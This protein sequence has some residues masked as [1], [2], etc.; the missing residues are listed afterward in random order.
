MDFVMTGLPHVQCYIDDILIHSE[1]LE[2]HAVH[3]RE[4]LER[5][6]KYGLKL[7]INKCDFG[8]RRI[9]YLGHIISAEGVQPSD[10]KIKAVR[11]FPEPTSVKKIREFTGLCN[12]FRN[13]IKNYALLSGHL[14]RLTK[15][16]CEWTGGPLPL[17]AKTAFEELRNRLCNA[18]LLVFPRKGVPYSISVDAA[19]GTATEPGGLGAILSQ[20]G[21]DGKDHVVA[22][23]SR[24]LKDFER[25]YTPYLLELAAAVWAIDHF[26]V[27]VYG[28][29]FT[30]WT[31]HRPIEK[32]TLLHDK[33]LNRL[34]QQMLI[35]NFVTMYRPGPE[36]G[37][38]DALSRN[39]VDSL[40]VST[41]DFQRL[42]E[43]DAFCF[44]IIRFIQNGVL[45]SNK[46]QAITITYHA[47]NMFLEN[48]VLYYIMRRK[49]MESRQLVVIPR[50]LQAELIHGAH[51]TRYS[52]HSG[53]L[54]T[55]LRL[56]TRYYWPGMTAQVQH[57]IDNCMLCIKC[58]SKLGKAPLHPLPLPELPNQ[59]VHIDLC[60]PYKTTSSGNKYCMV[61]TDAFTKY[62][63][64]VAIPNKEAVTIATALLQ[65][66]VCKFSVMRTL[67]SDR[68]K[69]FDN[70]VL[71]ELCVLM[72]TEKRMSS[73]MNPQSNTAVESWNRSLVK[74]LTMAMSGGSTL[75]WEK[76]LP[77]LEISYNTQVH[78]ST[79]YSPFYLTFLHHPNLPYFDMDDPAVP[80][81]DGS[82][83]TVAFQR[84][85][86]A[87]RLARLNNTEAVEKGKIAYDKKAKDR[88]FEVGDEVLVF[89]PKCMAKD[90]KKF[91]E[92]WKEGYVIIDQTGPISFIVQ[93]GPHG[94]PHAVQ[95][96]RL[97]LVPDKLK[98]PQQIPQKKVPRLNLQRKQ[99]F[100]LFET[101]EDDDDD[102]D[103]DVPLLPIPP[104]PANQ[105]VPTAQPAAAALPVI[106]PPP[107]GG[108][109]RQPDVGQQPPN[110][111]EAIDRLAQ[112]LIG[113]V[114]HTRARG[115]AD[116]Q[117][118]VM[119]TG[120]RKKK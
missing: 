25:N 2:D 13:H 60:G 61:M 41:Y 83:A 99:K 113:P 84:M 63:V 114:R 20:H 33:T 56:Q 68:G 27:Y 107:A 54:K 66:W 73:V 86:K 103:D 79:L 11:D 87:Y 106:P 47:S 77:A 44:D 81:E 45:P 7:N 48:N 111:R 120:T 40:E 42:Q 15:K 92:Q 71:D 35:Y 67:I 30:L 52:G 112:D 12:Y 46:A 1:N 116:P 32:M 90:N 69:E 94:R 105:P 62:A 101:P 115:P 14:S 53:V 59:R 49:G 118:N 3:V 80:E 57:H 104:A 109:M 75:E 82:W 26:H 38:P 17:P 78:R 39:P 119:P 4:C 19:T 100:V 6:E 31:D 74:Y 29:K 23:A 85:M 10:D 98:T 117:P 64:V 65:H 24:S 97:L 89:F 5:L 72:G 37:G 93:R 50:V 34:K 91:T 58:K 21:V 88:T 9:K 22:Y 18:P 76:W 16:N 8:A 95:Q 51:S 36:N 108:A 55:V 70:K 110:I 28:R 43:A 102:E 96:N